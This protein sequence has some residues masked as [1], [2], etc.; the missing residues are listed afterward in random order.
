M[1][2]SLELAAWKGNSARAV[3]NIVATPQFFRC[4]QLRSSCKIAAN[5]SATLP[6]S[7]VSCRSQQIGEKVFGAKGPVYLSTDYLGLD[8]EELSSL[9]ASTN[10]NC[11]QFPRF[12]DDGSIVPVNPAKLR[13]ALRHS[14]V[15]VA[16][17]V[18]GA[19]EDDL[20]AATGGATYDQIPGWFDYLMPRPRGKRRLIAFGRATSDASL[21]ASIYDLAVAPSYQRSGYGGRVLLRIVREL[22]RKGICD[23]AV[24][25]T[26]ELRTFFAKCGFGPDQLNS[27]TMMYTRSPAS[28]VASEVKQCGRN[29]YHIPPPLT[30]RTSTRILERSRL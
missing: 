27:T 20:E 10:Q 9:L 11:E 4:R 3:V 5:N 25:P 26:P 8:T 1:A 16:L 29:L 14:T 15:V 21:T 19:S 30:P 12:R 28:P 23:I 7:S 18:E 13:R 6:T 2:L 22:R 17:Y 24:T